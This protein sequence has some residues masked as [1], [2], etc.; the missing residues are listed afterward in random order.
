MTLRDMTEADVQMKIKIF[1]VFHK[2]LDEK[3]FSKFSGLEIDAYFVKYAVNHDFPK[4]VIYKNLYR[5]L[6]KKRADPNVVYEYQLPKYNPEL[7]KRGFM[8]T[9][10][11]VHVLENKLYQDCDY[12][13]VCQYDMRWTA[14]ARQTLLDLKAK[15]AQDNTAWGISVG[16]L[17]SSE[18]VFHPFAFTDLVDW[19][20]LLNS[21]NQFFK[22]NWSSEMLLQKP[23]TLFQ[24]YLLPV[25]EY[26]ALAQWLKSLTE[27]LFPWANQ[28][29]YPTHWG[30]LAGCIERAESLFFAARLHEQRLNFKE[31]ALIHDET[32][33]Q[34]LGVQKTHYVSTK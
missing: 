33:P 2:A 28:A 18:K 13:G 5:K 26:L 29:P 23:F 15:T 32:I 25:A 31:L 19:D 34:V 8:E 4:N 17:M 12:I 6:T 1:V 22:T 27:E 24:T 11:Y 16:E 9:S 20:F 14:E 7:Q 3:I 10:C 21:Y 30:H